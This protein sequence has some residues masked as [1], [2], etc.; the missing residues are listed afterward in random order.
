M[1][2]LTFV[3]ADAAH[4]EWQVALADCQ[5]Q[6]DTQDLLRQ[7]RLDHAPP[8]TLGWCYLSDYYA[9]AAEAILAA[10][11]QNWPGVSWIGT[12]GL[13]VSASGVEYFDQPAMVLL[14]APFP[15]GS[16]QLFSGRQP[17]PAASSG[18]VP[19]TALVHA[20]GSTPDVQELLHELSAR[21]ATG[22]LFGGLS[23]ARNRTLHIA[24]GVYSGGLSGVLFG[25]EVELVSRVTQGCQPIGPARAVTR[26]EHNLLFA[27]DGKP[28]LDCVLQDLGV[29]RDAP[30]E[31][32]AAALSG[33][34]AG[35][36]ASTDDA[37]VQPGRFGSDTLVRHLI[38]L[39]VQHRVLA[40]ADQVEP[41]M[42]LA[43]CMRN[44]AAA[45]ADLERIATE[46]RADIEQSGGHAR[47]ALYISCS[48]RGGPHFGAPHAELQTVRGALGDLPLAGFF[49][50]GE[51]AR[52]HLYGYT[53]VLTVFT[54][55]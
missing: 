8:L 10:L 24:D 16:F 7:A 18:F 35:L 2:D 50:G 42:R 30:V 19:H 4:T 29:E 9:L 47:G 33:T 53:G 5:R 26:S 31:A 14:A 21:T 3:H 34:L 28:A 15:R 41:G 49:A 39:D 27:L 44:A 45:R 32:M 52:D 25:P 23:S 55:H 17:L 40:L 48:G 20:E 37:P 54:S 12:V 1:H 51:I 46:V 38:G 6:L 22:Y 43:F 11:Q 13:G 36:N